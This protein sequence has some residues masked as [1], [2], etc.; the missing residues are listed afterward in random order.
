MLLRGDSRNGIFCAGRFGGGA[1]GPLTII[2][3]QPLLL[4]GPMLR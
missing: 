4:G 3:G 1:D 2:L